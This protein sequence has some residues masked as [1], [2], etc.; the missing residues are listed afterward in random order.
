MILWCFNPIDTTHILLREKCP[1]W[2]WRNDQTMGSEIWFCRLSV[3]IFVQ[4]VGTFSN[5]QRYRMTIE[6]LILDGQVHTLF[7]EN[8]TMSKLHCMR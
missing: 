2:L 8:E 5:T 4:F 6:N 1:F 3:T 7:S